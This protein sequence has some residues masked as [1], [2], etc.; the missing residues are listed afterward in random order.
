MRVLIKLRRHSFSMLIEFYNFK[1]NLN[2]PT[3]YK[4]AL[5]NHENLSYG[6]TAQQGRRQMQNYQQQH[7][8]HGFQ[9]HQQNSQRVE[10]QGQRRSQSFEDQMI[11][12]MEENK[13]LLNIHEQKFVE[14]AAF[15]ANTTM[16]QANT[17]ASVKNL[18][19]QVGQLALAMQNQSKDA[20]PNV[21]KKNPKDYMVVT[22]RSGREIERKKEKEKKTEREE[23][24]EILGELKQYS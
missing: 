20:F 11:S 13:I 23:K 17:N 7:G 3:H 10:N 4:P 21:T 9:G 15:Q 12:F 1:P 16:F 24:K 22:L 2:L 8:Q 19:K 5:R 14:L 6:L 18:E